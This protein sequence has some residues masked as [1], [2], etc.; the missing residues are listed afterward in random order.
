MRLLTPAPVAWTPA[1]MRY[2]E[3]LDVLA[4][5][6]YTT[7]RESG[8]AICARVTEVTRPGFGPL[9]NQINRPTDFTLKAIGRDLV[10]LAAPSLGSLRF[11]GS[12]RMEFDREAYPASRTTLM[13]PAV[14]P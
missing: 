9:G 8:A 12:K 3:D 1:R 14:S 6:R 7:R 10:S 11:V 13:S 2:S 5:T 4:G